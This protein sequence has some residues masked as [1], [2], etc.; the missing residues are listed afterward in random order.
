M[1]T[2]AGEACAHLPPYVASVY[3]QDAVALGRAA[4]QCTRLSLSE[5]PYGPSPTA[6][7][8]AAAQLAQLERYPDSACT[9]LRTT[10]AELHGVAPEQLL[11]ANGIDELLHLAGHAFGG[12]GRAGVCCTQTYF[13]HVATLQLSGTHVVA[14]QLGPHGLTLDALLEQLPGADVAFLCNPHNPTGTILG[15]DELATLVAAADDAACALVLDEAYAEF[16]A[17]PWSSGLSLLGHG[18]VVVLRTFS[19][20][21]GLAGLRCGY[22]IA[23]PSLIERLAVARHVTP[24]SVNRVA[25]AAARAAA[26]DQPY[27]ARV[28]QGNR[29]ARALLTD[30]LRA[31][32]HLDYASHANFLLVTATGSAEAAATRLLDEH[33]IH[34]R[35]CG[36]IGFP[37]HV[38]VGVPHP[39]DAAR[40]GAALTAVLDDQEPGHA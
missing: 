31:A 14:A 40:V 33:A 9:E 15:R 22:A 24:F 36:P 13:G 29:R 4:T 39:D 35:P 30:E 2:C 26:L 23:A 37:R 3:Q 18:D 34:A 27:L 1:S 38:R 10:L 17:E 12:P 21:Y 28:A 32:G 5:S 20:A 25:L 19:K 6:T 11:V 16:A 8:A 7:E